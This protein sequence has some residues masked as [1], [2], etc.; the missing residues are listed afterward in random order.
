[1][2]DFHQNGIITTL[3]NFRNKSKKEI[4]KELKFFSKKRPIQLILPSLYSEIKRPALT[5]IISELNKTNYISEIII[6]LDQANEKEFL[7][8]KHFFSSL[9]IKHKILWNDAPNLI[10][11]DRE[12]ES[13]GLS[14][15]NFGKG[16]NVWYCMGY[17]IA[18]DNAE[19]IAI[20]DC[21]IKTYTNEIVA[22]LIYPIANP[23]LNFEFCKGFYP[24]VSG[25]KINGRV[26][27]LLVTP[28][29]KSLKKIIGPS[30]YLDVIDAFRYTLAGE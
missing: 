8:A 4:E 13:I 21:D 16:R 18:N 24:R 26:S 15:K 9:S 2:A 20:H 22:K 14:P 1:M 17:S 12:L 7:E 23:K 25:D 28:L 5:R 19:A 6:G 10:K 11:L 29:L 3:H 30:D 27:R